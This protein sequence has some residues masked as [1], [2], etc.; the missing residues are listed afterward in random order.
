MAVGLLLAA[1][2]LLGL[3]GLAALFDM[4][5]VCPGQQCSDAVLMVSLAAPGVPV[6]LCL[7]AWVVRHMRS[8]RS[9]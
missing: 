9:G 3:A 1:V 5:T 8:G 6:L 2:V 7:I 4:I